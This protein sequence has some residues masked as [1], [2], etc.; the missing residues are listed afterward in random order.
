ML[1]VLVIPG[2]EDGLADTIKTG[3]QPGQIRAGIMF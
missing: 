2:A 1:A 3:M